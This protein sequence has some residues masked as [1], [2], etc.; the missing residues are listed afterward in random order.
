MQVG[1]QLTVRHSETALTASPLMKDKKT[2]CAVSPSAAVMESKLLYSTRPCFLHAALNTEC[3]G[4]FTRVEIVFSMD[5]RK[6]S[7]V[8]RHI[9]TNRDK[10]S[11][12][13][14]I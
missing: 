1:S 7:V 10:V 6:V 14:H 11:Q 13:V 8:H 2:S 12:D 4:E 3:V 5:G 9:S